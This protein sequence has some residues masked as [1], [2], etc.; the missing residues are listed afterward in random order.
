[1]KKIALCV[2][3]CVALLF[4]SCGKRDY[5]NLLPADAFTVVSVN[6]ASIAGK[7]DAGEP[8]GTVLYRLVEGAIDADMSPADRERMLAL[9][10]DPEKSGLDPHSDLFFFAMPDDLSAGRF[11]AGLL[12]KVKDRAAVKELLEWCGAADWEEAVASG[13]TLVR[14]ALPEGLPEVVAFDDEAFL[15]LFSS[16]PGCDVEVVAR[17]LFAQKRGES[18]MHRPELSRAFDAGSDIVL[19]MNYGPVFVQFMSQTGIGMT[20]I[21]G[22]EFLSRMSY[23]APVNFE[24][25]RIVSE[26]SLFFDGR[27]AESQY[28]E[29]VSGAQKIDGGFLESLP[30]GNLALAA[31]S[32]KGARVYAML[33]QIPMYSMLLAMA[34]QV[35]TILEAIDG[36]VALAVHG[37]DAESDNLEITFLATAPHAGIVKSILEVASGAEEY[38]AGV[39]RLRID[40]RQWLYFGERDGRFYATTVPCMAA[41]LAEGCGDFTDASALGTLFRGAYGAMNV[42]FVEIRQL[43]GDVFVPRNESQAQ[44]QAVAMKVLELFEKIEVRSERQERATFVVEMTDKE[45]N[46]V[47]T[48]YALIEE[49]GDRALQEE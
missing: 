8:T 14:G 31:W 12:G 17:R 24:K 19:A 27:E 35:Q 22:M 39:Y 37:F 41:S 43:L 28:R 21:P 20:S 3:L 26:V 1:M 6:P 10:A 38:D 5:R 13:P 25:G 46:A 32:M 29:F 4:A 34:P 9:I 42:D 49:L 36:D 15:L 48:I 11:T 23:V 47:A 45:R 16:D 33:Q 30:G 44:E 40:S 18:L 7:A 2:A